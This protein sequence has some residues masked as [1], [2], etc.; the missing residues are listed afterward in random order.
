MKKYITLILVVLLVFISIVGCSEAEVD[1][2]GTEERGTAE[3]GTEE[4]GTEERGT[5]ETGT[6]ERGKGGES[7][8]P[9]SSDSRTDTKTPSS[10][11]NTSS[12]LPIEV[13][14]LELQSISDE[15][16]VLGKVYPYKE[17]TIGSSASGIVDY[18]AVGIGDEIVA[19][20]LMY[21][22]NDDELEL[23]SSQQLSNALNSVNSMKAKYD[24]ELGNYESVTTLYENGY[25]SKSE[26]DTAE[27]N[28]SAAQL[29]YSNAQQTYY[30]LK[31]STDYNMTETVLNAPISGIVSSVN[32]SEGEKSGANDITIINRDY[33]IIDTI[34]AGKVVN[35]IQVG[36]EVRILYDGESLY[37]TIEEISPVG[38]NG[39]DSYSVKVILPDVMSLNIGVN[40]DV[41]YAVN[42]AED[43]F[44]VS[45]KAVLTD[46]YGDYIYISK[47]NI[48]VKLYIE[49]G[50]TNNGMV[51][52][53][54][55]LNVGDLVVT[56]GQNMIKDGQLIEIK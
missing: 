10:G 54:G 37:G 45:K 22:I 1:K 44:V 41:Y 23:N 36:D 43:Q 2:A 17:L 4:R 14:E 39:T 27:Y 52:I 47:D 38:I 31:S 53:I 25:A 13:T 5:E 32:V 18:L 56:N 3:R 34:V 35:D 20:E 42:Q 12:S 16:R 30:N 50:F 29:N 21:S 24:I 49:Q 33:L 6:E 46:T 9:D 11:T 26:F 48:A 28:L 7:K 8:A 40:V 55:E 51:Q 19:G 15:Y